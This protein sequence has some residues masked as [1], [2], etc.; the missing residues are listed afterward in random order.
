MK[1]KLC[2]HNVVKIKFALSI[3]INSPI[4]KV[5]YPEISV[6]GEEIFDYIE[7][8][9]KQVNIPN[10]GVIMIYEEKENKS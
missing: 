10:K 3:F 2:S 5:E 7:F 1:P 9:E 8:L 6:L 4:L